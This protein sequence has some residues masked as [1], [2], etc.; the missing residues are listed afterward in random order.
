MFHSIVEELVEKGYEVTV[1]KAG[2]KVDGFYKSGT[3]LLN[4]LE[5]GTLTATDRYGKET[6]LNSF[7]DLVY[8][9]FSWWK[10]S[11][12]RGWGEPNSFWL[13]EF[14]TLG[15]VKEKTVRVIEEA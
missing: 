10:T 14:K 15:L 12:E 3:V 5:D 4:E 13:E 6:V 1:S 9:N 2:I 11:K 7:E 8:L